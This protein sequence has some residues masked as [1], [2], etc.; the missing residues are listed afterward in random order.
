VQRRW[1]TWSARLAGVAGRTRFQQVDAETVTFPPASF[2]VLWSIECT[3][4]LVDK[5]PFSE[6]AAP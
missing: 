5:R 6:R 3:E 2:D 1:A 4:Q